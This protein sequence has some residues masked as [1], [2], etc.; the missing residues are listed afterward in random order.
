MNHITP[1]TPSFVFGYWKPWKENSNAFESYVEYSRDLALTKYGADTFGNYVRQSSKE[2]ILAINQLGNEIGRGINIISNKIDSISEELIEINS[3]LRFINRNL[4]IQIEQQKLNNLLL[5]NIAEL[6]RVPNSEKERQRCIEQGIK[7][8]VNANKYPDL[9]ADALEEL[10]KAETLMKQDYFVLHRIG[11]IYLYVEKFINPEKA[12]Q[13]FERAGKYA[14]Y[15][16][17]SSS[18]RLANILIDRFTTPNSEINNNI[19]Q[20]SLLAADSFEKAAF[21]AYILGRFD[22]AVD[23][24]NKALSVNASAENRFFLAK[25]LIRNG[26][27]NDSI[28]LLENLIHEDPLFING[29]IKELDFINEPA[30]LKLI[31]EI[32]ND[33]NSE[34]NELVNKLK[35]YTYRTSTE[36]VNE[37]SQILKL[38]LDIRIKDFKK[39]KEKAIH[40]LSLL[41]ESEN[42]FERFNLKNNTIASNEFMIVNKEFEKLKKLSYV[43]FENG[44]KI[45]K[46]NVNRRLNEKTFSIDHENTFFK[47]NSSQNKL[48]VS[49]EIKTNNLKLFKDTEIESEWNFSKEKIV[50]SIKIDTEY[51]PYVL[52]LDIILRTTTYFIFSFNLISSFSFWLF[53]IILIPALLFLIYYL[54]ID[55]YIEMKYK[56]PWIKKFN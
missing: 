24:Q 53:Q 30:V 32:N 7:Y 44:I 38:P 18:V 19:E 41:N 15:E 2:H 6:L 42:L 51:H 45:F 33:L 49:S 20:I 1:T 8:F 34:I 35:V 5:E 14:V 37:L 55:K 50:K 11:C 54:F 47:I 40:I 10:L 28:K 22:D 31:S 21:S 43:K 46:E 13:Y 26:S 9:Y 36:I 4:D 17:D 16:S 29:I 48:T 27:I 56:T 25:Y 3:S 12:I 52:I 39:C 23:F